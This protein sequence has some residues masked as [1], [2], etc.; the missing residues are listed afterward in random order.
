MIIVSICLWLDH[1]TE[2]REIDSM[3]AALHNLL[4]IFM[5]KLNHLLPNKDD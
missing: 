2:K 5:V 3:K 1:F 4:A